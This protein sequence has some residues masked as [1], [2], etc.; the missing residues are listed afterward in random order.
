MPKVEQERANGYQRNLETVRSQELQ[1][2]LFV[3]RFRREILIFVD[4]V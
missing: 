3:C 4:R 1:F 2:G